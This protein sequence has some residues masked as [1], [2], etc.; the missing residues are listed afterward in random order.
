MLSSKHAQTRDPIIDLDQ[1]R[2]LAGRLTIV[3]SGREA[4]E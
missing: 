4:M 1:R 2:D 3:F